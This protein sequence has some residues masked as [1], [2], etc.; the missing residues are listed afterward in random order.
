MR[1]YSGKTMNKCNRRAYDTCQVLLGLWK[2]K[3]KVLGKE[4]LLSSENW[5]VGSLFNEAVLGKPSSGLEHPGQK[6]LEAVR[7]W[8]LQGAAKSLM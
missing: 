1:S 2:L 4:E 6:R 7:G 8:K 3:K 5:G